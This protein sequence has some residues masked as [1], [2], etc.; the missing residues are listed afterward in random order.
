MTT[1]AIIPDSRRQPP[2][3]GGFNATFLRLEIRRVLRNRRT[4]IFILIMPTVFFLLFGLPQQSQTIQGTNGLAYYM[5]S[6]AVYGAMVGT[7]S[8]GAAV[9]VERASGWSRQLRL[10]PLRPAAYMIT[11]ILTAMVLGFV[12]VVVVYI[13][14]FI[15][16][17][18][19][20][21]DQWVLSG[22][23]AWIGALVFAAFGIFMGYLL[24][25]EN[26]MQILGPALAILALF[27]GLFIPLEFL[28]SVL[29]EIAEFT[30]VYG[31]G[32]IA[33]APL[34]GSGFTAAA[35]ANVI[36]WLLVFAIGAA[37]LFRRDTRRV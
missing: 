34:T 14:G 5:V 9:A 11:K 20:P 25:S 15:A 4:M 31:V 13:V 23:G 37:Q 1:G 6:I 28:P 16:G 7:T 21:V 33:R 24:P 36:V 17:V 30:P 2:S 29:Q 8:T 18:R 26:V 19:L 12:A 3:L 27:G 22:L 35:V 32:E 10:T